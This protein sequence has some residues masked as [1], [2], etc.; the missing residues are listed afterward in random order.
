MLTE[1]M[2][3]SYRTKF[4]EVY[5]G[6]SLDLMTAFPDRVVNLVVTSPPFALQK[7]KAYGNV[8]AS[9]YVDWLL[10]FAEQVQRVL[11]DDGSL[12]LDLG[13]GWTKG[14]PTRSLYHYEVVIALTREFGFH[15]AQEF[16]WYN[17]AKL[18]TPAECRM[19]VRRLRVKDAVN[20]IWWLSKSANPKA[21]NREFSGR[22]Q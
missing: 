4:G 8:G 2:T 17:P 18:P 9:E 3:P 12:V 7:Q 15:L 1:Q 19:T 13:G 22:L 21:D 14:Q 10:P 11:T 5:L 6:D 20:T 16:Y